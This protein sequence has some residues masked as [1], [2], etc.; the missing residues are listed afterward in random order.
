LGG[1]PDSS[2]DGGGDASDAADAY[3]AADSPDDGAPPDAPFDADADAGADAG[4]DADSSAD[5]AI[6]REWALWIMPN[7]AEAGLP[8]PAQYQVGAST[9]TDLVT[10]LVWKNQVAAAQS[11]SSAAASCGAGFRVPTRIE[12]ISLI[13]DTRSPAI[14][15]VFAATPAEWFWTTSLVIGSTTQTWSVSFDK[16]EV[17]PSEYA[18]RVRCVKETP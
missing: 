18:T 12:L 7:A 9:T 3:D 17:S 6:T 15:P 1:A 16:G 10:G 13:D 5:S 2:D 8:N 11:L 14:D 4:A